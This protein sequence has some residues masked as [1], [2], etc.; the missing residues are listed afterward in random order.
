MVNPLAMTGL[1]CHTSLGVVAVPL[2]ALFPESFASEFCDIDQGLTLENTIKELLVVAGCV[3]GSSGKV[4]Q[5]IHGK[6]SSV[7]KD[8]EEYGVD[9]L[10]NMSGAKT[11]ANALGVERLGS[12]ASV[13]DALLCYAAGYALGGVTGAK[14]EPSVGVVG[15]QMVEDPGGT[16][17]NTLQELMSYWHTVKS[18][19]GERARRRCACGLR[20]AC[21]EKGEV[22]K[23]L[24]VVNGFDPSAGLLY[25]VLSDGRVQRHDV[26]GCGLCDV[27]V[28]SPPYLVSLDGLKAAVSPG[29]DRWM[30]DKARLCCTA[31]C[32]CWKQ[33]V[34]E[35]KD[36]GWY[37]AREFLC[38]G[39]NVCGTSELSRFVLGDMGLRAVRSDVSGLWYAYDVERAKTWLVS[40]VVRQPV[41][42][43]GD[44]NLHR[45]CS[46]L[47]VRMLVV[48]YEY[49]QSGGLHLIDVLRG[50]GFHPDGME[51]DKR[52]FEVDGRMVAGQYECMCGQAH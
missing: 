13:K 10:V 39:G 27:G 49:I 18:E 46:L 16:V 45:A 20:V 6:A 3:A 30:H 22:M 47:R 34:R 51:Y 24:S 50:T 7:V 25:E 28:G 17:T 9:V 35:V 37:V 4:C 21:Q 38:C 31:R 14:V 52:W 48:W 5:S 41:R 23:L 44:E 40:A 33:G 43:F 42:V 8:V 32:A 26:R 19:A 36:V 11:L 12:G 29:Y 1:R 2:T 15:V